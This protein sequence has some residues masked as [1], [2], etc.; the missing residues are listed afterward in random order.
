MNKKYDV[1]VVGG[2]FAGVT[3]AIETARKGLKVLLV[4][5]Y[6]CLGGAMSNCFVMPFMPYWTKWKKTRKENILQA[7]FL[8]RLLKRQ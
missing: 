1:I 5:K 7:I 2:G 8:L 6:N 3:A 4:E